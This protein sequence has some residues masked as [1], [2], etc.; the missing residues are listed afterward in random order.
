MDKKFLAEYDSRE[1][2]AAKKFYDDCTKGKLSHYPPDARF[3]GLKM[4][5]THADPQLYYYDKASIW[6]QI[7]LSGTLII[8]LMNVSKK[9]CLNQNG[10]SPDEIPDLIKFA[11]ETG[12]IKFGL[13]TNPLN[14][15]EQDYLEPI[16]QEFE[17][18]VLLPLD[19]SSI[20]DP[21]DV[22]DYNIEFQTLAGIKY[23]ESIKQT[24]LRKGENGKLWNK[25]M[26]GKSLTYIG[27]KCLG[28]N[29]EVEELS[30]QM[31]DDPAV[32]TV[33]FNHYTIL[34]SSIFDALTPNYNYGFTKLQCSKLLDLS[35]NKNIKIPEI[36]INISQHLVPNANSYE[37]CLKL[38]KTYIDNDLYK[39]MLDLEQSVR[40]QQEDC[41]IQNKTE[42]DYT[43]D[44]M[45]KETKRMTMQKYAINCGIAVT[46][47]MISTLS[48]FPVGLFSSLLPSLGFPAISRYL[49][50][51]DSSIGESI[52]RKIRRN[53]LVTIYDFRKKYQLN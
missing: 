15:D 7:P 23:A 25:V 24:F 4:P 20:F 39:L 33:L 14:Y 34:L 38:V 16:L 21:N 53:G 22:K 42:L 37:G 13:S 2:S 3:G 18:P 40:E 31:I 30:Q 19:H 8:S 5:V 27:L 52:I 28:M 12:K 35:K 9:M 1:K 49:R 17:P 48:S 11:K 10:F 46:L 29:D 36:G 32:A 50:I 47:G 51:Q 43:L 45:W 26:N 44:A 41:V 6:S